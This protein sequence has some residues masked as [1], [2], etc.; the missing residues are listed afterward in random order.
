MR[1]KPPFRST[2]ICRTTDRPIGTGFEYLVVR[3]SDIVGSVANVE[4]NR[5]FFAFSF[6]AV[7]HRDNTRG[8]LQAFGLIEFRG[9][10]VVN[11]VHFIRTVSPAR[12]RATTSQ[13]GSAVP[14]QSETRR[15]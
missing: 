4:K 3:V 5:A 11:V 7:S 2:I 6:R 14:D 15:S 9:P 12:R 8:L 13:S 10:T 1:F